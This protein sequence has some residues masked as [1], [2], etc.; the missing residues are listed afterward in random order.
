MFEYF[1]IWI[2][3]GICTGF[4]TS[5]IKF[6]FKWIDEYADEYM[7]YT[8]V[9][10]VIYLTYIILRFTFGITLNTLSHLAVLVTVPVSLPIMMIF[11]IKLPST[12]PEE[13][14]DEIADE[15]S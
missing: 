5:L 9:P 7:T 13:S 8:P 10:F 15:A 2:I 11:E 12:E 4:A 6:I 3:C 1:I 14:S